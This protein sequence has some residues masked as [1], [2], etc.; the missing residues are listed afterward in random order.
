MPKILNIEHVAY[1]TNGEVGQSQ[2]KSNP[3][4]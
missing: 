3:R 1:A 2:K 4:K